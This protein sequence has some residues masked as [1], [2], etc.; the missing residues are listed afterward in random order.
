MAISEMFLS[1]DVKN[2]MVVDES[3]IISETDPE[4]AERHVEIAKVT[5]KAHRTGTLKDAVVGADVF[6]GVSAPGVLK[7]EWISSMNERPIIFAMANPTPEIFSDEAKAGGAYIVG[8]AAAISR[9]RSTMS[10]RSPASSEE[11]WMPARKTSRSKCKLQL[12]KG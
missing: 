4:L 2:V 1:A 6:V 11:P 10:W 12:R 8:P 3:G 9:I 7:K 5:N